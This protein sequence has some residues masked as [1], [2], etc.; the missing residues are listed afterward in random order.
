[1]TTSPDHDFSMWTPGLFDLFRVLLGI[2]LTFH[3]VGLLLWGTELFSSAGMIAD[4]A[5]SP[6]HA[7]VPNI[8]WLGDSPL[9]VLLVIA[10][11]IVAA[12]AMVLKQCDRIAAIWILLVLISLFCRNPLI[13]NPGMPYLGSSPATASLPVSTP[14]LVRCT[15]LRSGS[16]QKAL[17]VAHRPLANAWHPTRRWRDF[18]ASVLEKWTERR[19]I[20]QSF[21][22]TS[23]RACRIPGR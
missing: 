3:F 19:P 14:A 23:Q 17:K 10:S 16:R 20:V 18:L 2:Y 7:L 5:L 8:F 15:C 22:N 1:M 13:A 12:I 11:G 4:A 6:L 21:S 9:F